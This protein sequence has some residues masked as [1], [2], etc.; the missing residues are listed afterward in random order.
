MRG[1]F[2]ARIRAS[3]GGSA[4]RVRR[5]FNRAMGLG[6][7]DESVADMV[8]DQWNRLFGHSA[9]PP[10]PGAPMQLPGATPATPVGAM[11]FA[12]IHGRDVHSPQTGPYSYYPL[13]GAEEISVSGQAQ[14]EHTVHVDVSLEPGLMAKINQVVNSLGFTVP[15]IGG[16]SG[17]MDSDAGPHRSSGGIGSM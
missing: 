17:R 10:L 16:G 8:T 5:S 11:P 9:V 1:S 7:T 12:P 15:L 2:S 4:G 14:V 6:D 13:K 3:E